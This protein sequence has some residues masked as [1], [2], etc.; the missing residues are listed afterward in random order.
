M[1]NE[2]KNMPESHNK[3]IIKRVLMISLLAFVF[4]AGCTSMQMSMSESI[5]SGLKPILPEKTPEEQKFEFS[6]PVYKF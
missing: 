3:N 1:S 5:N 4:A 2:L 6:I